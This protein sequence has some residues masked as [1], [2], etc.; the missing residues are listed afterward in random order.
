MAIANSPV[1]VDA[2]LCLSTPDETEALLANLRGDPDIYHPPTFMKETMPVGHRAI[3]EQFHEAHIEATLTAD[4]PSCVPLRK[5]ISQYFLLA[6]LLK[7]N[8]DVGFYAA[9]RDIYCLQM[10]T[11]C[12]WPQRQI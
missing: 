10:A 8:G 12:F 1:R 6:E 9:L 11:A 7:A 2:L 5:N 3:V 4:V